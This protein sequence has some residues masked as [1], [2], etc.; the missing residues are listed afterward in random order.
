MLKIIYLKIKTLFRTLVKVNNI[1]DIGLAENVTQ[2]M[3]KIQDTVKEKSEMDKKSKVKK[4][5]QASIAWQL[6]DKHTEFDARFAVARDYNNK[7]PRIKILAKDAMPKTN[8]T[9]LEIDQVFY[10]IMLMRNLKE[11][12][13]QLLDILSF[14][15]LKGKK[16]VKTKIGALHYLISLMMIIERENMLISYTIRHEGEDIVKYINV[17][18][19]ECTSFAWDKVEKW[20]KLKLVQ[21]QG[22]RERMQ[23][24]EKI[25]NINLEENNKVYYTI[26]ETYSYSRDNEDDKIIFKL[27]MG[28]TKELQ[29]LVFKKLESPDMVFYLHKRYVFQAHEKYL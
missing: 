25:Y 12:E 16:K 27:L 3:I 1:R 23:E 9:T 11:M 17:L 21:I 20:C 22:I 6:A 10:N 28:K 13:N 8:F 24:I 5:V 4:L 18:K 7:Y 29:N 2:A 15:S 14:T 26:K 19:E